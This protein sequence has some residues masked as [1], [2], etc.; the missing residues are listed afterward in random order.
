MHMSNGH[1]AAPPFNGKDLLLIRLRVTGFSVGLGFSGLGGI[2]P[3]GSMNSMSGVPMTGLPGMANLSSKLGGSLVLS[4]NSG[5]A[6]GTPNSGR[7]G[8]GSKL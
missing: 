4:M 6:I 1:G 2:A 3:T 7:I 8:T 5:S